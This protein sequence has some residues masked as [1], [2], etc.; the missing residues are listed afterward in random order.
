MKTTLLVV[1]AF[2][3]AV[4]AWSRGLVPIGYSNEVLYIRYE[5][6]VSFIHPE[7]DGNKICGVRTEM[8]NWPS[9]MVHVVTYGVGRKPVFRI[10]SL[11][12]LP[13]PGE[14]WDRSEWMWYENKTW[15]TGP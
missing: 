10:W 2:G 14:P 8:T 15:I 13:E 1:V 5:K 6:V 11:E 12:L 7:G 9:A 4:S 3:V